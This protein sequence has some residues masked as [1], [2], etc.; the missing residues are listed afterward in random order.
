MGAKENT[1]LGK[2]AMQVDAKE[3]KDLLESWRSKE[4]GK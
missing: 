2:L 4:A 3:I 1:E